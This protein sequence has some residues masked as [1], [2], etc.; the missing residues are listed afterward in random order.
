[1]FDVSKLNPFKILITVIRKTLTTLIVFPQLARHWGNNLGLNL[2][3]IAAL[4]S[5]LTSF[6]GL[7]SCLSS[8]LLSRENLKSP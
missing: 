5:V 6:R 4:L 7:V 3:S 2:L 8:L 1:M